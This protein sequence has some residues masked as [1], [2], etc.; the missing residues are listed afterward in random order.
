MTSAANSQQNNRQNR[1]VPNKSVVQ[2]QAAFDPNNNDDE[3]IK[4]VEGQRV[5]YTGK[6]R[7]PNMAMGKADTS[8]LCLR[9]NC[10]LFKKKVCFPCNLCTKAG[11]L[12]IN[13]GECGMVTKEGIYHTI[14]RPG[15]Y[16]INTSVL[17]VRRVSLKL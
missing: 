15:F 12:T 6:F 11:T 9:E 3:N 4:L 13:P 10:G 14:L 2:A 16:Y 17:K 8:L 7:D 5:D 1:A